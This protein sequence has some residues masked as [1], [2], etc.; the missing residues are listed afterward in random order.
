MVF[1]PKNPFAIPKPE[2]IEQSPVLNQQIG[3]K[4]TGQFAV[5]GIGDVS[6]QRFKEERVARGFGGRGSEG[7]QI[8]PE[9]AKG[10][11]GSDEFRAT[12][13]EIAQ[14]QVQQLAGIGAEDF[15]Q[16]RMSQDGSFLT[17]LQEGWEEATPLQKGSIIA[18]GAT[19]AVAGVALGGA[20]FAGTGVAVVGKA[21]TAGI[22]AKSAGALTTLKS[23]KIL[24]YAGAAYGL[25]TEKRARD[26]EK[27]MNDLRSISKEL[28]RSI[29][30]GL[31]A[32]EVRDQLVVMEQE[33]RDKGA[34]LNVAKARSI[35]DRI[36]KSNAQTTI[37]R[38]VQSV[39]IT[40]QVVEQYMMDGN[41]DR[42]NQALGVFGGEE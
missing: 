28:G 16:L 11:R 24:G 13:Q 27:Q 14:Q 30:R 37:R 26:L 17:R 41:L 4:P 35:S 3:E 33:M 12:R 2:K 10:M 23:L 36:V 18:A 39:V 20:V 9:V 34:E 15:T 7:V 31:D 32:N 38:N 22:L 42:L 21:A 29:N 8:S 6:E 19:L 25:I 5:S 40:R 1:S